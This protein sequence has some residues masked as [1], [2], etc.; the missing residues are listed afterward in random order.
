MKTTLYVIGIVA[1]SALMLSPK[2]PKAYPP[3]E[4]IQQ[5]KEIVCKEAKIEKIINSIESAIILDSIHL[6]KRKKDE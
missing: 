2:L 3:K 5:R 6:V 1:F 4:V